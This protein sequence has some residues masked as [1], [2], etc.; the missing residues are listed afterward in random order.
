MINVKHVWWVLPVL[1][2]TIFSC[3][4]TITDRYTEDELVQIMLD[5]HTLGLIYNRQEERTDSLKLEYYDVL[6]D[7]YGLTRKEFQELVNGLILNSKLY[8]KVYDRMMKKAE[9]AEHL[10]MQGL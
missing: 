4:S 7:R 9:R 10:E 1:L 3:Q 8:D 5:A 2:T 6:E